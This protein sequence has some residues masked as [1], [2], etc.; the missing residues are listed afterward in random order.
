MLVTSMFFVMHLKIHD[1][2]VAKAG[3]L[4]YTILTY[5]IKMIQA[6]GE[7]MKMQGINLIVWK[8]QADGSWKVLVDK[9]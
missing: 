2:Q 3:D 1:I 8:K 4:G 6:S 9:E 7:Q 5:D